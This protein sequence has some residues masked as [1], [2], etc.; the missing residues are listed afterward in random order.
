MECGRTAAAAVVQPAE[1]RAVLDSL[2]A[3]FRAEVP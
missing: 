1:A 3:Q 2:Y